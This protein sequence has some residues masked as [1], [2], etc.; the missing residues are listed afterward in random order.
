M[1]KLR[2]GDIELYYEKMGEGQPLVFIHGLGSSA[3][4]WENQVDL[5]AKHYQVVA[6]DVRGHGQS[7]KP[8][9]PYSIPLF[10]Q[11]AAGLIESLGIAPAHVV[12]LSLGGMI[13]LQLAV[14]APDALKSLTVVNSGPDM[15]LRTF[16]DRLNVFQRLFV[17]SVLGMRKMG[18]VLSGRLFPKPEHEEIR[19]IFV[20]RW[21]ANDKPAYMASLRAIIGWSVADRLGEIR[22]PT[23][24]IA[25]D[26]DYTPVALK[27]AYAAK[28]PGATL[29]V[30]EDSRHATHVER[31]EAFNPTLMA[32]LEK[33]K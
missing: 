26:Q 21:A 19:Q 5:F 8:P 28:I 32:F 27:E 9:G 20:E 7:D 29:A 15:V 16:K 18:E 12:G 11:D 24:V 10:A 22:C 4:G 3:L 31:P 1:P 25:A 14:S 6:F 13:A 30:I 33:Q 23:L 2:T 17:S